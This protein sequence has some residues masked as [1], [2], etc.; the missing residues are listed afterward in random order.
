MANPLAVAPTPPDFCFCSDFFN[1]PNN[2][3]TYLVLNDCVQAEALMPRGSQPLPVYEPNYHQLHF[4][5]QPPPELPLLYHHGG[6][7]I[8]V[9]ICDPYD[10]ERG[11]AVFYT[12]PDDFREM[13]G[14][15]INQCVVGHTPSLG[16][17]VTK[18]ISNSINYLRSHTGVWDPYNGYPLSAT[19]FTVELSYD[20]RET[21]GFH[22]GSF[23]PTVGGAIFTSLHDTLLNT[24][25]SS[26]D[27]N[28]LSEMAE[29]IGHNWASMVRGVNHHE[30]WYG[31]SYPTNVPI[32]PVSY[33]CDAKLGNPT[34]VDCSQ[35]QY[36]QFHN[37]SDTVSLEPGIVNFLHADTCSIG[38]SASASLTM[39]W[40]QI[41]AAVNGLIEI[42]VNNPLATA[43]GGR[44]YYEPQS[45]S[46][47]GGRRKTKKLR[48]ITALNALP[49][50]ANVSLFRQYE[51]FSDFPPPA[52]EIASCTW[53][54]VL[55]EQDVRSCSSV[56]HRPS[57]P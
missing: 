9:D 22:S 13:A 38:I 8:K 43:V 6:C 55:N 41:I 52:Q 56:H 21:D 19:F 24:P 33:E 12:V 45:P 20:T 26:P 18:N 37:Q 4:I 36:S 28:R 29:R 23:D 27:W 57:T 3:E 31:N 17:F 14:W 10:T 44:A 42:C 49:P 35:L 53:Q 15:V 16:G 54:H 1:D 2:Y 30:P 34:Q 5:G 48:D 51:I 11:G 39:T 7:Q 50:H 32:D 47:I 25:F 46:D 40:Q